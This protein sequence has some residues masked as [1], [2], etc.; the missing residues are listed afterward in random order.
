M[1][2]SANTLKSN[3]QIIFSNRDEW[4]KDLAKSIAPNTSEQTFFEGHLNLKQDTAG[5][6]AI[7]GQLS[8]KL[9]CPCDRCGEPVLLSLDETIKATFRPAYSETPPREIALTSEDL[10]TYFIEDGCI[11]LSQLINDTVYLAIP[12]QIRCG[13]PAICGKFEHQSN[14]LVYGDGTPSERES[15]FSVLKNLNLT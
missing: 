13:A 8:G 2:I 5:F 11:D 14:D 4:I 15:P 7:N 3:D 6:V 1:K 10:D 12:A 9:S